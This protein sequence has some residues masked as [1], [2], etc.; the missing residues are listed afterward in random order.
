MS[1]NNINNVINFTNRDSRAIRDDLVDKAKVLSKGK[2]TDFSE[3]DPGVIMIEL[4]TYL[5]DQL[6]FYVD[7]ALRESYLSTATDYSSVVDIISLVGYR[8][9]GYVTASL[10]VKIVFSPFLNVQPGDSATLKKW[11][12]FTSSQGLNFTNAINVGPIKNNVDATNTLVLYEGTPN[13]IDKSILQDVSDSNVILISELVTVAQNVFELTVIDS[14]SATVASNVICQLVENVDLEPTNIETPSILGVTTVRIPFSLHLDNE[15]Y[16]YIKLH[17]SWRQK[18]AIANLGNQGN[19]AFR[20]NCVSTSGSNGNLAT[21]SLKLLDSVV[22]ISS[23]DVSADLMFFETSGS[24]GGADPETISD[25]RYN[26]P[27]Y[28]RTMNRLVTIQDYKLFLESKPNISKALVFDCNN[29][30]NGLTTQGIIGIYLVSPN[31]DTN[32]KYTSVDYLSAKS[33]LLSE[34]QSKAVAGTTIK[35]FDRVTFRDISIGLDVYAYNTGA[36]STEISSILITAIR[37]YFNPIYRDFG[38]IISMSEL[39]AHLESLVL[40]KGVIS[41]SISYPAETTVLEAHEF[42]RLIVD[43]IINVRYR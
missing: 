25:I 16:T 21:I 42:P 11:T 28:T 4:M 26:V 30:I 1:I 18:L 33:I 5:T 13:I 8:P 24:S 20:I 29:P 3:A 34:M 9:R 23:S 41:I 10:S 15:G 2:W 35:I 39:R 22:S 17:S 7:N 32:L 38:D 19:L 36:S 31:T 43:P 27:R 37:D 12:L 14:S 40:S 6:N